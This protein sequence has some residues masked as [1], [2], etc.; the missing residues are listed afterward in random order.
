MTQAE[1]AALVFQSRSTLA[2]WE[3]D[4]NVRPVPRLAVIRWAEATGVPLWW[5]LDDGDTAPATHGQIAA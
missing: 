2:A 4:R 3:N 1:M 5:L